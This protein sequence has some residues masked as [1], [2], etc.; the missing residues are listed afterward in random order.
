MA[1]EIQDEPFSGWE[2]LAIAAGIEERGI[3]FYRQAAERCQ[4]PEAR[5]VFETLIGEE[6][7]HLATVEEAL[8]AARGLTPVEADVVRAY[9]EAVEGDL[10]PFD[11]EVAGDRERAVAQAKRIEA[12][13]ASNYLRLARASMDLQAKAV[14]VALAEEELDHGRLLEH[15]LGG[16]V[17]A[18]PAAFPEEA[19]R[20]AALEQ[21]LHRAVPALSEVGSQ[22]GLAPPLPTDDGSVFSRLGRLRRLLQEVEEELDAHLDGRIHALAERLTAASAH[23]SPAAG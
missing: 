19:G 8:V 10:D 18:P 17:E 1:N 6:H 23:A 15:R 7:R 9:L 4:D 22:W 20:L 3:R 5:A 16:A 12:V 13:A 2:A 21:E 11:P 14:L